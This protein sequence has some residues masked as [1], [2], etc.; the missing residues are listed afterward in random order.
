MFSYCGATILN[1]I[2]NEIDS[3]CSIGLF[4]THIRQIF[5][6][7]SEDVLKKLA[8]KFTTISNE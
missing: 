3:N 2:L 8:Y 6:L 5:L 4:K 1:F 7:Y